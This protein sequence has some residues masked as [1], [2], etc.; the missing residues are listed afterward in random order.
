VIAKRPK[1]RS[2][3]VPREALSAFTVRLETDEYKRLGHLA[4]DAEVSVNDIVRLVL[5]DFLASEPK[6]EELIKRLHTPIP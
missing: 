2:G 4:V 3:N 5:T 1:R 6:A